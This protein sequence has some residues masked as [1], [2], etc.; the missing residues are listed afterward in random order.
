MAGDCCWERVRAQPLSLLLVAEGPPAAREG[1]DFVV[2]DDVK[3]AAIFQCCGIAWCCCPEAELE[4]LD[5]DRVV[6]EVL[7]A[8]A[9]PK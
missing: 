2:P 1:R 9:V 4:G 7:A 3:D 8:T 5:T 6:S